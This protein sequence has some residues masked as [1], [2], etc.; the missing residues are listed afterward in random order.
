MVE[1]SSKSQFSK[2]QANSVVDF[3]K[4]GIGIIFLSAVVVN[5]ILFLPLSYVESPATIK[6]T[7]NFVIYAICAICI[8]TSG[9][10][11]IYSLTEKKENT[12][13]FLISILL[14]NIL[15]GIIFSLEF[16]GLSPIENFLPLL[17]VGAAHFL[18]F[19]VVF[20][21]P[22]LRIY[23]TYL[24]KVLNFVEVGTFIFIIFGCYYI[25]HQLR[26]LFG[27]SFANILDGQ[28]LVLLI[29]IIIGI[30]IINISRSYVL[31]I[32]I[33]DFTKFSRDILII[34]LLVV[35]V[36]IIIFIN[37]KSIDL[38]WIVVLAFLST[39]FYIAQNLKQQKSSIF[40]IVGFL[41][42]LLFPLVNY[43]APDQLT[44]LKWE[45][46]ISAIATGL[47]IVISIVSLLATLPTTK[48]WFN[49]KRSSNLTQQKIV[50]A[51]YEILEVNKYNLESINKI[52]N[53]VILTNKINTAINIAKRIIK[54][55]ANE[56]SP[57]LLNYFRLFLDCVEFNAK[58]K[59]IVEETLE[60]GTTKNRT[61]SDEQEFKSYISTRFPT[62]I[63]NID[64]WESYKNNEYIKSYLEEQ[65]IDK[66]RPRTFGTR[67]KRALS[68]A[69]T[70]FILLSFIVNQ[71]PNASN[72]SIFGLVTDVTSWIK[73]RA[74]NF[75]LKMTEAYEPYNNPKNVNLY[76]QNI[77][78]W[79]IV[80]K[81]Y[82]GTNK[83]STLYLNEEDLTQ[84]VK[85]FQ[86]DLKIYQEKGEFRHRLNEEV[87]YLYIALE[88]C[89]NSAKHF[90]EI[91][92]ESTD[93]KRKDTLTAAMSECYYKL[94]D[95]EKAY[96]IV[97]PQNQ[98]YVRS[99]L[100]LAE[101]NFVKGEYEKASAILDSL[102]NSKELKLKAELMRL[103]V[104]SEVQFKNNEFAKSAESAF[105]ALSKNFMS[106]NIMNNAAVKKILDNFKTSIEKTGTKSDFDNRINIWYFTYFWYSNEFDNAFT[107]LGNHLK[108]YPYHDADFTDFVR[109]YLKDLQNQLK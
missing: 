101:L 109:K 60:D 35:M 24:A 108:K 44:N 77:Y 14:F 3:I 83:S 53:I 5:V 22:I 58:N 29:K 27:M 70:G 97:E 71:V 19:C 46:L 81:Y 62:Y 86:L 47:A 79:A 21:N 26:F 36:E 73:F 72:V 93:N 103:L 52:M 78:D 54:D 63:F 100:L 18:V 10:N 7:F 69:L 67:I 55:K 25:I 90:N 49:F 61:I 84:L 9:I 92:S 33:N 102:P 104:E 85:W 106:G 94:G 40:F 1:N 50:D 30:I 12:E 15:I 105:T 20:L 107:Y 96:K 89:E 28:A 16:L 37:Q 41:L 66:V 75:N 98:D 23:K 2:L 31:N 95:I 74:V 17:F 48:K 56:F 11:L 76:A 13:S 8:F 99:N 87:G 45:S 57:E 39:V 34:F 43:I 68:F 51:C 88:D 32:K 91:L 64:L 65:K 4:K 80:W 6:G 38:W 42:F 82:K 59:I